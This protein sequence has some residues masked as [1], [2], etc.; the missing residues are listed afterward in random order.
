MENHS[1]NPMAL[2]FPCFFGGL[3]SQTLTDIQTS[4]RGVAE[5]VEV[6]PGAENAR[7]KEV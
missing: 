6:L 3:Q 4:R 7:S 5:D 1:D 2:G